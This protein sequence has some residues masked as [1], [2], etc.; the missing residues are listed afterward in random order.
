[1]FPRVT[2]SGDQS[3]GWIVEIHDGERCAVYS[4]EAATAEEAKAKA[5]QAHGLPA[6]PANDAAPV[7]PPTA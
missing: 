3:G 7:P 5:M 6:S 2:V 1:M 4:P